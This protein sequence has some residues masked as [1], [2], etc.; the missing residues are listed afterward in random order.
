[1]VVSQNQRS[2][3]PLVRMFVIESQPVLAGV[4]AYGVTDTVVDIRHEVTFLDV[5][6]LVKRP[7]YMEAET[8][9]GV[10]LV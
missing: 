6:H 4:G 1:M 2:Q 9:R 5:Q 3:Q 10:D 8:V 7:R